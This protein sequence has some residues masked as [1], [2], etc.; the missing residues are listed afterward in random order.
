MPETGMLSGVHCIVHKHGL[1]DAEISLGS[2]AELN[3]FIRGVFIRIS[4]Q[5]GELN[6]KI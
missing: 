2:F 3:L 5:E 6:V 4:I 1:S